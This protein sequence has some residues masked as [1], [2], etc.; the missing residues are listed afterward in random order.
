MYIRVD[1]NNTEQLLVAFN[2]LKK[3]GYTWASGIDLIS[4]STT[5]MMKRILK[6]QEK[7]IGIYKNEKSIKHG[8]VIV[9]EGVPFEIFM[10]TI[11]NL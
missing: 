5:E 9:N 3:K 4:S 11:N 2:I 1:I 10:K 8:D 7:S 6:S